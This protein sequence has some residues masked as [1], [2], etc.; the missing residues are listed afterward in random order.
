MLVALQNRPRLNFG[1]D[2][3]TSST[4]R[5]HHF[6]EDQNIQII[7]YLSHTV[8]VKEAL[9]S[10]SNLQSASI[11]HSIGSWLRALHDW[12]SKPEQASLHDM[13]VE[14]KDMKALKWKITYEQGTQVLKRFPEVFA[15]WGEMWGDIKTSREAEYGNEGSGTVGIV[16]GDFWS[17]KYGTI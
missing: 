8:T 7:E 11:G 3:L 6:I 1:N 12:T 5:L 2:P 4:P 17:G 10:F 16:H 14:N 15:K 9:P 13:M